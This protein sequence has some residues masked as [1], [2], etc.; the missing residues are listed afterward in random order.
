MATEAAPSEAPPKVTGLFKDLLEGSFP[1]LYPDP[2][3][4][5]EP[6][7][8]EAEAKG[9]D[10]EEGATEEAPDATDEPEPEPPADEDPEEDE[11]EPE[12]EP[13]P[14]PDEFDLRIADIDKQV[15]APFEPVSTSPPA[16]P[17]RA[18]SNV[19]KTGLPIPSPPSP[20]A[21]RDDHR[22]ARRH[23]RAPR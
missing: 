11:D 10:A 13:T 6:E 18:E 3:P 14:E 20:D 15:R 4:E 23:R 16:S 9:E 19:P 7:E 21:G 1:D 17:P 2:E 5:P 22:G 12:R 8:D